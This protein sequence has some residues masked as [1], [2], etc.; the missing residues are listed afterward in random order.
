VLTIA[1]L[2]IALAV[3]LQSSTTLVLGR[4][5]R[6]VTGDGKPEVLQVAATGPIENLDP[7]FTI[8]SS[9]KTIYS[10]RLAPLTPTMGFDGGKRAISLEEHKARLKEFGSSFF[11]SRKFQGPAAFVEELRASARLR[12]PEIPNV[13]AG[14]RSASEMRTGSEIWDE[15]LQSRVT[16]FTFS[17]GGDV[18]VPIG[19]SERSGRFYRLMDCC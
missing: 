1:P 6:D 5:E 18:I 12:V 13:I 4:V 16:I 10:Y 14:D 19:W 9:G 2:V 8:Q 11:D 3:S 15:I 17:P 7:V